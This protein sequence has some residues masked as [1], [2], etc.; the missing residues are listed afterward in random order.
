VFGSASN[1][2]D[3]PVMVASFGLWLAGL[4]IVYTI[5]AQVLKGIYMK[6]NKE[7]V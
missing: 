2:F 4:M 7:W 1:L 6:K 5:L 3:L